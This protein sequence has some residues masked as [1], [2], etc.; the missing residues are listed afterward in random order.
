MAL[1]L[2]P[3]TPILKINPTLQEANTTIH[4]VKELST[5]RDDQ[6]MKFGNITYV[7][8]N[9]SNSLVAYTRFVFI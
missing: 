4:L 9:E 1:F 6:A 8:S 2:V 5:L 7:T 3:G